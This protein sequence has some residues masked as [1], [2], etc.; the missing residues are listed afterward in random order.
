MIELLGH[1][2]WAYELLKSK[3]N[4][5]MFVFI[6][7]LC[8][9][10]SREEV[11]LEANFEYMVFRVIIAYVARADVSATALFASKSDGLVGSIVL[12]RQTYLVAYNS[13]TPTP[14]EVRINQKNLTIDEEDWRL[15]NEVVVN[16]YFIKQTKDI[17]LVHK[18]KTFA[19]V[20][21]LS[22]NKGVDFMVLTTDHPQDFF[23][24]KFGS[25]TVY[26]LCFT[27]A[28][29]RVRFHVFDST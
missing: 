24:R 18:P 10:G 3:S 16:I 28:F 8:C 9:A 4:R 11:L 2:R 7:L 22:I 29:P 21:G 14:I 5:D 19:A 26:S 1:N 12:G 6:L 15:G 27:C 13:S 17:K 25:Q 20:T 23:V